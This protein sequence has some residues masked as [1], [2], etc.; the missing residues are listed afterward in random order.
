MT[1][2][3]KLLAG[4]YQVGSLIGHGG[5]ADVYLGT[6]TRL[7]RQVAIKLLRSSLANDPRFRMMFRE[8]A[9]KASR[10]AHPTIVKVLD[11]G[12]E[13]LKDALGFESQVPFIVMEHVDGRMLKDI[14]ADGPISPKEAVRITSQVLTALEYAHRALLV[15]RDIKPGN[16]MITQAGQVKVMD[17]GIARAVS[18]NTATVADTS[19]MLGTAKYFSPEQARGESVDAR[20]DLYSTGVILFELLT[21]QAPF[22]GER[23]AALAYQHISEAPVPPSSINP[24][25]PHALDAV[26]L[27]ALTKNKHERYQS[28]AEFRDELEKAGA[29]IP[30]GNEAPIRSNRPTSPKPG[31]TQIV[32]D[33][34]SATLFGTAP[35][36]QTGQAAAIRN[37]TATDDEMISQTQSRP[38]VAWVWGGIAILIV[39]LAGVAFWLLNLQPAKITVDLSVQIPDVVGQPYDNGASELT[40]LTLVPT[41]LSEPSDTVPAG[42]IT[43]LDP[44]VGTKVAKNFGVKVWVSSGRAVIEVPIVTNMTEENA[45]KALTDAGLIFGTS[46]TTHDANVAK[47]I[48]VGSTPAGGTQIRQG[49]TVD[50][51]ISDGLVQVPKVVGLDITEANKQLTAL[52]LPITLVSDG[53]CTGGKVSDQS[54]APGT[55]PQQ[56]PITLT[57][58]SG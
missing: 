31:A 32:Q 6:D 26:V 2:G 19:A 17:F 25:V 41:R 16:V 30:T 8:E 44:P 4:R 11:A 22:Q 42:T 21:G 5:M 34:F 54:L 20:T 37:V 48:V 53:G 10:M 46:T 33:D 7:G 56:S 50:L 15:H 49:E 39:L 55:H 27:K 35:A 3:L 47:G 29:E 38:P 18:D 9:E 12:E 13:T 23:P 45:V 36:T 43:R 58:C 24:N 40:K 1:E 57:Y 52:N 14:I 28:A 51:L